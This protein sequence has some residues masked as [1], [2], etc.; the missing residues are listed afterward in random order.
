MK[1]QT[2]SVYLYV[3]F[4]FAGF[5]ACSSSVSNSVLDKCN[6]QKVD[7]NSQANKSSCGAGDSSC[8]Q[9]MLTDPN[10]STQQWDEKLNKCTADYQKCLNS[11]E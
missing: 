3:L 11:K 6:M 9:K 2:R 1:M 8:V 7:C 4:C 10:W 5:S